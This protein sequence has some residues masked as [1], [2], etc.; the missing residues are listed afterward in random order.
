ME[1]SVTSDSKSLRDQGVE[2]DTDSDDNDPLD[3]TS[4]PMSGVTQRKKSVDLEKIIGNTMGQMLAK[5]EANNARMVKEIKD[6]IKR[7]YVEINERMDSHYKEFNQ[8]KVELDSK[9]AGL[10][11]RINTMDVNINDKIEVMNAKFSVL[12]TTHAKDVNQL[13]VDLSKVNNDLTQIKEKSLS[14]EVA[15]KNNKD[16]LVKINNEL[17]GKVVAVQNDLDNIKLSVGN[18]NNHPLN[19]CSQSSM[20]LQ[21]DYYFRDFKHDLP[22]EFLN[23]LELEYNYNYC[24]EMWKHLVNSRLKERAYLWWSLKKDQLNSFKEFINAFKLEFCGSNFTQY[25]INKL[26]SEGYYSQKQ[27]P[28][29]PYIT[30]LL[31]LAKSTNITSCENELTKLIANH[32]SEVISHTA[33]IKDFN[34]INELIQYL[35][36]IPDQNLLYKGHNSNTNKPYL[37]HNQ[38]K[39]NYPR[40]VNKQSTPYKY[41]QPANQNYNSNATHRT[42]RRVQA[43]NQSAKN[44]NKSVSPFSPPPMSVHEESNQPSTSQNCSTTIP[45]SKN[46]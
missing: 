43:I 27:G 17:S 21:L 22:D 39:F 12:E 29:M 46:D 23:N 26:R 14:I 24:P 1:H 4:R 3:E 31:K 25:A 9:F 6:E 33:H 16:D 37:N 11:E 34:T 30:N 19:H 35:E 44:Y 10:H 36:N 8:L 45:Q 7:N 41:T 28:L 13:K 5:L 18:S 20:K 38:N 32:F 15:V 42:P 2:L 40:N